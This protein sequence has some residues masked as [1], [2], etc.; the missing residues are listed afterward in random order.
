MNRTV[1]LNALLVVSM[2]LSAIPVIYI[3]HAEG[4]DGIFGGGSGAFGDPYVIEDVWD[5]QAMNENLSA[6]YVLNNDIDAT[7]TR[8]WND[9]AGFHPLGERYKTY[10]TDS[11]WSGTPFTGSLDGDGHTISG[12][13]IDRTGDPET[14]GFLYAVGLFGNI[15]SK[16]TVKN[17]K[18]VGTDVTGNM[19]VGGLAGF[20]TGIISNCSLTGFVAGAANVGGLVGQNEKGRIS[21]CHVYLEVDGT[22]ITGEFIY[23][24]NTG[25]IVG[26]NT[27]EVEHCSSSGHV[28]GVIKIGGLIGDNPGGGIVSNCG[29]DANVTGS[30]YVGGMIGENGGDVSYCHSTGHVVSERDVAGGFI[31]NNKVA[32]SVSDCYSTGEVSGTHMVGGLIGWNGG[33]ITRCFSTGNVNGNFTLGGSIGVNQG[34]ISFSFSS[35]SVVAVEGPDMSD[36]NLA[37]GFI[38][39]NL[40]FV[41]N[42][43]STSDVTVAEDIAGGLIAMNQQGVVNFCYS[44]GHVTSTESEHIGGLVGNNTEGSIEDSYWDIETSGQEMSDGGEGRTTS[45]MMARV[46]YLSWDFGSTWAI[47]DGADYPYLQAFP[48]GARILSPRYIG[49][50][51]KGDSLRFKGSDLPGQNIRYQWTFSDGRTSSMRAP[52]LLSFGSIGSQEVSYSFKGEDI[53]SLEGDSMD[54]DVVDDQRSYPDLTVMAYSI[55][56]RLSIGDPVPISY[57]VVN[58][59]NASITGDTWID[60]IY[61]SEDQYLDALDTKLASATISMDVPMDGGY[62]GHFNITPPAVKEGPYHLII[63]LNDEWSFVEVHRL[64]NERE[65]TIDIAIP[66]LREGIEYDG[67]YSSGPIEHYY[68]IELQS[69]NNIHLTLKDPEGAS[70]IAR[71]GG[72]PTR[73]AYDHR[74]GNGQLTVQSAYS[75]TWYVL[76]H[77]N[78]MAGSGTYTIKFDVV[79][80]ILEDIAPSKHII[81]VPVDMILRGVGFVEPIQV[82]FV[83]SNGMNHEVPLIDVNTPTLITAHVKGDLLP[84]GIYDVRVVRPDKGT[85]ELKEAVE[86]L[87]EGEAKFEAIIIPG[88]WTGYHE[89][90]TIYVEYSNTGEIS[91]RA[92][93]LYITAISGPDDRRGPMLT[94]D[95]EQWK[96]GIWTAGR[97]PGALPEVPPSTL[98]TGF[99]NELL[100]IAS[101]EIPGILQAGETRRIP[102]YYLGWEPPYPMFGSGLEW[103]LY[104]ITEDD[105]HVMEWD[106]VKDEM[107]PDDIEGGAWDII[108]NN[109]KDLVGLTYGD[110]I[111][112]LNDNAFHLYQHG[113]RLEDIDEI[114]SLTFQQ[115]EGWIPSPSIYSRNDASLICPGLDLTFERYYPNSISKR[116]EEGDLG[117]GWVHNWQYSLVEEDDGTVM[118]TDT[119]GKTRIF[120]PNIRTRNDYM[121]QPGDWGELIETP[122]GGFEL[123]EK[124]G[125]THIFDPDGKLDRIEDMNGNSIACQYTDGS[126][127]KLVHSSGNYIGI[128]YNGDALIDHLTDSLGRITTYS[129]E[130]GYLTSVEYFDGY[131]EAYYYDRTDGSPSQHALIGFTPL[132]DSRVYLTYNDRGSIRS[133]YRE[134]EVEKT[135]FSYGLGLMK[136][137]DMLG[138]TNRFFYDHE[139]RTIGSVN[140]LGET[141]TIVYDELGQL[142]SI[143]DPAG[144]SIE[145]QNH[146]GNLI[147]IKGKA[148]EEYLINYHQKLDMMVRITDPTGSSVIYDRDDHGNVIGIRYADG[149]S[150]TGSYDEHGNLVTATNR[151][152]NTTSFYY[153]PNGRITTKRYAD[154]SENQ[155]SYDIRGNLISMEDS[156]GVTNYTYNSND[157]LTRIEY[158]GGQW[159]EFTYDHTRRR[160][161][162]IDHMGNRINYDHDHAGRLEGLTTS[163]GIDVV[164]YG[165]DKLGR[166]SDKTL[167]NGV[168]TTYGYDAAGR[169]TKLA[170]FHPDETVISWF[171]YTYD[172]CGRITKTNTHYGTWLYTYDDRDQLVNAVFDPTYPGI[173]AQNM[174]YDHD[175]MGNRVRTVINGEEGQYTSNDLN[176]YTGVGDVSYHYDTDGNLVSEDGHNGTTT[177]TYND[178]GRLI[179]V[180]RGGDSWEYAYDGLGNRVSISENGVPSYLLVDPI[181]MGEVVGVYDENQTL[182]SR[183]IYGSDLVSMETGTG[184]SYF[185]N[186]DAMGNT[187]ELTDSTGATVNSYSYLPFGEV[188]SEQ[189]SVSNP[190]RFVGEKGVMADPSGLIHMRAREYSPQMGRFTSMDPMG[191]SAGDLNLYRYVFNSPTNL[192][193]PEGLS[194]IGYAYEIGTGLIPWGDMAESSTDSFLD[195]GDAEFV[196]FSVEVIAGIGT[197]SSMAPI[198]FSPAA[199]AVVVAA[200]VVVVVYTIYSI[201]KKL[202]SLFEFGVPANT[203]TPLDPNQKICLNGTGPGNHVAEGTRLS[204]II[205]FENMKE[206][207]APAQMVTV[208][209]PLSEDLD[210]S[211]F[212]FTEIGFGDLAI[213]FD[214]GTRYFDEVMEYSYEDDEYVMDIELHLNGEIDVRTGKVYVIIYSID[215]VTQLPPEVNIG[216]L[217]PED[218]TGRG[219]G[220][221]SYNIDPKTDLESGTEIRNIATIQFNLGMEIDTNQIDP[222][223]RSKGTSPDLEALVTIDAEPPSSSITALPEKVGQNFTVSWSGED[224]SGGSGI[225]SYDIYAKENDGPWT[226]WLEGTNATS[227]YY[228]GDVGSTYGFY[229]I[230]T[231]NVGHREDKQE[232]IEAFATVMVPTSPTANAGTDQ[233][234]EA[235]TN[236]TFDGSRSLDSVGIVSYTWTFNNGGEEVTLNGIIA[237]YKFDTPGTYSITLNVTNAAGLWDTDT[238]EVKV[239]KANGSNGEKNNWIPLMLCL[240]PLVLLTLLIV[241]SFATYTIFRARNKRFDEE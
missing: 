170:N 50:I 103:Q 175:I 69:S 13:F 132:G 29:S 48:P 21:N 3:D 38:G 53:V 27:G 15:G 88:P 159:L 71:H 104:R 60:S 213:P 208:V 89:H 206:A 188:L 150:E 134:G 85:A 83:G 1:I 167:Q 160:S 109:F 9:G 204:Y 225:A 148:G 155:Y 76:V 228:E 119:S 11:K 100:I 18:I 19:S 164:K 202:D 212:E 172:T 235:G 149:S 218:G 22:L 196:G 90:S 28:T 209:D 52:G 147:G 152:G 137:T 118:I 145:Y 25:G 7:E 230:A 135:S 221:F 125:H 199:P 165:Y 42:C 97:K 195:Q 72:L 151:R 4:K 237:S 226:P 219:Q 121:S 101:G 32:S 220:Y 233:R 232:N 191:I 185:Y 84:A 39:N 136:V 41:Q 65:R 105:E 128:A 240:V 187:H 180:R 68:R 143:T 173:S 223:D 107:R 140:A 227:A 113:Q 74:S 36:G 58:T 182:V 8:T 98:P 231:D 171:N 154:G 141:Y 46:T 57:Y 30:G 116:F 40:G 55:P 33:T 129:Y 14:E 54:F 79:D 216:F 229:S 203:L 5:L 2:I 92:P 211:T 12:L 86:I 207:T 63:S 178:D 176:Q 183:F 193:D 156:T 56:E 106:S 49:T 215:P 127:S 144:S 112:I 169:V 161:A 158:P 186:F 47:Y 120:Q 162:M 62:Q 96:Y 93:L 26:S 37:G 80:L 201:A 66:E 51:V 238:M 138:Y 139:G 123:L 124:R 142:K 117:R 6:H 190:F 131:T 64:N 111:R 166:L 81:G 181:G 20:N 114:L 163:G 239:E 34:D 198:I 59:G 210:W 179:G 217:P 24:L 110:L 177:Y 236:V 10:V 16:G 94:H 168:Y 146:K 200:A 102:I 222:L 75:G 87:E 31:A 214:P 35:G 194:A 189:G 241:L 70:I 77:G 82:I 205:E 45:E 122:E 99:Q 126:L 197:L 108:W 224:E 115:A 44:T 192:V 95:N 130:D 133:S 17:L 78:C 61:F 184:D 153:D 174:E 91:M 234:V 23:N 67:E 43:Y 73:S 157:L